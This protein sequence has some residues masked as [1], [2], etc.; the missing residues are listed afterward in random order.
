MKF[1]APMLLSIPTS[2][3]L[4]LGAAACGESPPPPA[5]PPVTTATPPPAVAATPPSAAPAPAPAPTPAPVAKADPHAAAKAIVDAPDRSEK[6][7]ALDAGRHP[8]ELLELLALPAGGKVAEIGA[9]PG[10]T[11]ELLVRAV[12]PTGKVFMQNEPT[13]H[14]FLAEGLAERFTHPVMKT[15]VVVANERPFQDPF[16]PEAKDLDAVLINIIYHDVVNTKTDRAV[17]NKHVFDALRPG[18]EYVVV[19]TSAPAGSGVSAAKKLHRIDEQVVKDEITKAGFEL[20]ATGSFLKN[21]DDKRDWD[22]SPGAATKSGK[23]GT[24]D[25]FVFRFVRPR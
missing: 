14:A 15:A 5:P 23:R 13:W 6:D 16:P 2:I 9:G 3:A 10:Y 22:A 12:G 18:G 7:R 11:T 1:R 17:M 20:A 19:D 4:A 24:S 8:A 25:R 21:P